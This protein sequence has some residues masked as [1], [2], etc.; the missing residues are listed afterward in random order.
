MIITWCHMMS[1]DNHMMSHDN[2][3]MSHDVS[4]TDTH[5]VST[6]MCVF[7]YKLHLTITWHSPSELPT[8]RWGTCNTVQDA[9]QHFVH[10]VAVPISR[11]PQ[12]SS[13]G[14]KCVLC[15]FA[16][17]SACLFSQRCVTLI[18]HIYT[19]NG[20]LYETSRPVLI[21]RSWLARN[22][23]YLQKNVLLLSGCRVGYFAGSTIP[24]HQ[25]HT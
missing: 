14:P 25:P 17:H 8:T 11:S 4:S 15:D 16:Y 13:W 10:E 2:H 5:V 21:S 3:M 7:R 23:S 1:H 9:W 6:C 18:F 22:A 20:W 24:H 12:C 19:C